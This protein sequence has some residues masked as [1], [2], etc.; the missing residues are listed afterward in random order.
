M[1]LPNGLLLIA[2]ANKGLGAI[3]TATMKE[4]WRFMPQASITPTSDYATGNPP[5][6]TATPLYDGDYLWMG[7]NDG[8]LYKLDPQNGHVIDSHII[9]TP[10]LN[11]PCA[12]AKRI[13]VSD[14]F[15]RIMAIEK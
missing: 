12:D 1:K 2:S 10:V 3:D 11:R 14:C 15:G 7:A 4:A 8:I 6:I 5:S 9:G 13:Y